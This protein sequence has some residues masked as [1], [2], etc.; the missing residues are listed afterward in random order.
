[1]NSVPSIG[2]LGYLAKGSENAV[3]G[4]LHQCTWE[5]GENRRERIEVVAD[6]HGV[7][8]RGALAHDPRTATPPELTAP[9][10]RTSTPRTSR[11]DR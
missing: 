2:N 8:F 5:H 4:R 7:V 9:P 1:M 3:T 11:S 10:R 6:P